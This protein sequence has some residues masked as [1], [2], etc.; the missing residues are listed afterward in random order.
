MNNN[1][2]ER[3]QKMADKITAAYPVDERVSAVNDK[4]LAAC[5]VIAIFYSIGR[6]VYVGFKGSL[7]LPELILL[8]VMVAAMTMVE[9]QNH[10][11]NCPKTIIGG[12]PLDTGMTKK[13][14]KS[15]MLYY[16]GDSVVFAVIMS[17]ITFFGDKNSRNIVSMAV[18]FGVCLV[19]CFLLD[20]FLE[21][22]KVRK[23][24]EYMN[25]LCGE[26][27]DKNDLSDE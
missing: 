2:T 15:R 4:G 26:E 8:L 12:K 1:Y 22:R 9:R 5:G 11:Y 19:I 21:E 7:A 27:D 3:Q 23:Y 24:N 14:R 6:I 18:E 25:S 16:L 10:V 20:Y 17:V 13:A